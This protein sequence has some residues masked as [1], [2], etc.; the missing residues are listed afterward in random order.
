MKKMSFN[1]EQKR[2]MESAWLLYNNRDRI[3]SNPC[4]AYA[5]V[6]MPNGLM[7]CGDRAFKGATIGVYLEWWQECKKAI[8]TDEDGR[9][10][11]IVC[12]GGSVL[13]G[14]N[15]CYM[16]DEEG[17][18]SETRVQGFPT[19][20]HPFSHICHRYADGEKP[21]EPYCLEEVICRLTGRNEDCMKFINERLEKWK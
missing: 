13:S 19:L 7:Y 17:F 18:V 2:F 20:W 4:M 3:L 10:H 8:V 9:R 5:P 21:E 15:K 16:V 11:L 1:E 12:F 14:W 6:N